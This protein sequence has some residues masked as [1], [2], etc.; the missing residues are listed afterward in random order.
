MQ[1]RRENG[2]AAK[3]EAKKPLRLGVWHLTAQGGQQ[4]VL[5]SRTARASSSN[6][7][8]SLFRS[9]GSLWLGNSRECS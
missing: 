6:T 3:P 9:E 1:H 5:P 8:T 4:E 2:D 7:Y